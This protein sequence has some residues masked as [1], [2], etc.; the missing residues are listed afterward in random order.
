MSKQ[1][2]ESPASRTARD[3]VVAL[4][5]AFAVLVGNYF[6]ASSQ[7]NRVQ[8]ESLLEQNRQ[9][10]E[11]MVNYERNNKELT[12]RVNELSAMLIKK[13]IKIAQKY[14]SST[15]FKRSLDR[16]PFPV[17]IKRKTVEG[18]LIAL[19]NWYINRSY[20]DRF[21]VSAEHYKGKTDFDI[22]NKE[23]ATQFYK[24]DLGILRVMSSDCRNELYPRDAL[25]PVSDKNPLYMGYVCKWYDEIEGDPM[26]IGAIIFEEKYV[27]PETN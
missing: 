21:H 13:E 5:A 2:P 25:E 12:Q 19:R 22:W 15:A 3:V 20:E 6:T 7:D 1:V 16:M 8:M 14:D 18:G 17:F 27:L 24:F 4:I 9:L 23:T 11:Q 10:R 26:L